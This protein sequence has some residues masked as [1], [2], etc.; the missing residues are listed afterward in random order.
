MSE[1]W[2]HFFVL[3][4]L[5]SIMKKTT[6]VSEMPVSKTEKSTPA[7]ATKKPPAKPVVA[8][9][10][11][12]T[13]EASVTVV[14]SKTIP[15]AAVAPEITKTTTEALTT[16]VVIETTPE[17]SVTAEVAKAAPKK[18]SPKP[19]AAKNTPAVEPEPI[20][21]LPEIAM[22]ERVGFNAGSIWHYL[23]ENGATPV[24]KL[25]DALPVEEAIIQRSIGW[26]AQEDKITL[27][28]VDQIETIALKVTVQSPKNSSRHHRW[29]QR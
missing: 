25:I 23:A 1:W 20:A 13:P 11:K 2:K 12:T 14:T 8:E 27:S 15:K 17:V 26:L 21:A 19:K 16:T 28:V 6:T 29:Y 18:A 7:K 3:N 10:A 24:T 5:K 22:H 4:F 9:V